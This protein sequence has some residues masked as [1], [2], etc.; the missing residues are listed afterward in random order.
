MRNPT[1][2]L[3]RLPVSINMTPMIDV[4]FLLIIFFLVSSHLSKQE[5]H[6]RLELPNAANALDAQLAAAE[7]V[8]TVNVFEDD[9]LH[10]GAEAVTIQRLPE[11]LAGRAAQ[12]DG[13]LQV[14]IRCPADCEYGIV[15]PI[16]R[17]CA[18]AKTTDVVFAVYELNEGVSR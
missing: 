9:S 2:N 15:A 18:I 6:V 16:L 10:L 7:F 5:N 4:T 1:A 3:R 8:V 11:L 17:A 13:P 12:V 14:R